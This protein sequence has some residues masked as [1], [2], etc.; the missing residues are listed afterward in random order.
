MC[1]VA[2]L[3]NSPEVAVIDL[4]NPYLQHVIL[5]PLPLSGVCQRDQTAIQ[6]ILAAMSKLTSGQNAAAV[7]NTV[8]LP[9]VAHVLIS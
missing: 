1:S 4:S 7:M 3:P 8:T 6:K 9:A 2:R 5:S